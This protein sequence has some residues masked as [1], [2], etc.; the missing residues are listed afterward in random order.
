M[1][2][3]A[4]AGDFEQIHAF[5]RDRIADAGPLD[6]NTPAGQ[7]ALA[8]VGVVARHASTAKLFWCLPPQDEDSVF[9]HNLEVEVAAGWA[10]LVEIARTW[11]LHP[12]YRPE[13]F[14]RDAHAILTGGEG[15]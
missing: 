1:A 8:L 2:L 5:V 13:E 7:V 15:A 3:S 11:R 14:G 4:T 6:G 9:R 12:D 10:D